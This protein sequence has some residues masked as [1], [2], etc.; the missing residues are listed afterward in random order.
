MLIQLLRLSTVAAG[1]SVKF[2]ENGLLSGIPGGTVIPSA[3]GRVHPGALALPLGVA[4]APVHTVDTISGGTREP[5]QYGCTKFGFAAWL[6]LPEYPAVR[7]EFV[8]AS[9]YPP[10][11]LPGVGL[12]SP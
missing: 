12:E 5:L 4:A 9:W 10:G 11:L 7:I 8:G 2:S 6:P 1:V 3:P